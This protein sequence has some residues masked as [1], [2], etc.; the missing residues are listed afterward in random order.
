MIKKKAKIEHHQ[1]EHPHF[2]A[3][4]LIGHTLIKSAGTD[5]HLFIPSWG[6]DLEYW[7]NETW[8]IGMHNDIEIESFIIKRT[9]E[10]EIERVNHL[11]L[12]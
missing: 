10:E 11:F 4:L 2:R 6:L 3:A 8:G 1:S 5:S 7:M 12:R 9:N